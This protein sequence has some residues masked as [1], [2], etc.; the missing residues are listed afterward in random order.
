MYES[1][2][3]QPA[4]VRTY[5]GEALLH[6]A[7]IGRFRCFSI[8]LFPVARPALYLMPIQRVVASQLSE[9]F[10]PGRRVFSRIAILGLYGSVMFVWLNYAGHSQS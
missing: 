2:V 8:S 6:R 3:S 9:F 10:R 5:K 4:D 1:L 7:A